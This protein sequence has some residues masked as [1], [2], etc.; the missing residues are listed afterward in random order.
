MGNIT[1]Y[2]PYSYWSPPAQDTQSHT[3]QPDQCQPPRASV[4]SNEMFEQMK[5]I[6]LRH[7]ETMKKVTLL[8][9]IK[10]GI[11]LKHV[12]EK[13]KIVRD[14]DQLL[15]SI[16]KSFASLNKP[17][18]IK[19]TKLHHIEADPRETSKNNA[20]KRKIDS[21]LAKRMAIQKIKIDNSIYDERKT[22]TTLL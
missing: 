13:K 8:D 12:E 9:Q 10:A 4:F 21:E 18:D 15:D 19:C 6:S 5:T 16:K 11:E 1:S 2:T 3:I 14:R 7:V 17:D 22:R 20:M